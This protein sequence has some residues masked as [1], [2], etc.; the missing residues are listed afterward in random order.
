MQTKSVQ[1]WGPFF[2]ECSFGPA[3]A[4]AFRAL[5]KGYAE[6]PP[7]PL[8]AKAAIRARGRRHSHAPPATMWSSLQ[9]ECT[10]SP[11]FPPAPAEGSSNYMCPDKT[12]RGG[13]AFLAFAA[14]PQLVNVARGTAP[15]TA[16][17]RQPY[18]HQS[19]SHGWHEN[20]RTYTHHGS[21]PDMSLGTLHEEEDSDFHESVCDAFGSIRV[22][23]QQCHSSSW[24]QR[25]PH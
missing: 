19:T 20:S 14:R 15:P 23:Q 6:K 22:T 9:V 11:H 24:G 8:G 17:S 7:R 10:E 25:H 1:V 18:H 2:H 13:N 16:P 5:K 12:V 4:G 3:Q 21:P